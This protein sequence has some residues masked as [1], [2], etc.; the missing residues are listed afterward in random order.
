[1]RQLQFIL[2]LVL[3]AV[4]AACSSDSFKIDGNIEHL[5][6]APVRV[7]FQ[8]DSGVVDELVKLDKKGHFTFKGASEQPVIIS[9]LDQGN[10]LLTMVAAAN[11]DHLK[12]KGDAGK[13]QSIK[14]K[15]NRLNEDWQLFRDEHASFY[16]D[17]NPSRLDAAI[18]KFVRENPENLLS[19][20][21]LVADYGDYNDRDKVGK[22]LSSIDIKVRPQSL[23]R[24]LPSD[25]TRRS[26]VPVPRL[27]TLT[28][29]KHGGDFDEIKLTDRIALLS[30]WANPQP[31]RKG[32][33]TKIQ[34]IQESAGNKISVIDILAESDTMRWHQ[35]I[36]DES[37]PH[38]WAPGGPLEQGI[39][40]LGI[41]SLPWYAVT[42]SSGL[43]IYSG[44]NLDA[45]SKKCSTSGPRIQV[46]PAPSRCSSSISTVRRR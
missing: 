34:A 36:A 26:K 18:E 22:M 38:Y 10:N 28:L 33:A 13:A 9:L 24:V 4:L 15:G 14:V 40:L 21:L 3:T 37:W 27:T 29:I 32:L 2:L 39:Q 31:D 43:V 8:G 41:T 16:A 44:P 19:T 12:V 20:V 30:L 35:T 11:G 25:I 6:G 23:T 17:N 5:N 7:V 45:A 1:M 42:D 46:N